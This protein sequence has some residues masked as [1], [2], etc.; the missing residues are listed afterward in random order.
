MD[1]KPDKK[2]NFQIIL[3]IILPRVVVAIKRI[4]SIEIENKKFS[5]IKT[6]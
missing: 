6:F 2:E 1:T 4:L 5:N 3:T